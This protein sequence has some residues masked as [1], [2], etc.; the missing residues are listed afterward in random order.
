M[1]H[2][3]PDLCTC[4]KLKLNLFKDCEENGGGKS[5]CLCL[6]IAS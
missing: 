6:A 1:W 5:V 2:F 4:V 3:D